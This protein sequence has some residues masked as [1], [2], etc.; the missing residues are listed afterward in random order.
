MSESSVC[1]RVSCISACTRKPVPWACCVLLCRSDHDSD[2]DQ[3][4]KPVPDWARGLQLRS[5]LVAQVGGDT[6][7]PHIGLPL[8]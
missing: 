5:Q 6:L 2:D 3:P 1:G 4:K 8:S 7:H